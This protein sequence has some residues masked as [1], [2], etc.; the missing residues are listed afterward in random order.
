MD[1]SSSQNRTDEDNCAQLNQTLSINDPY[2]LFDLTRHPDGTVTRKP[3]RHPL[4]STAPD[5]SHPTPV[6]SK[7]VTINETN[8]TRVRIFLP[9]HALEEDSSSSN[10]PLPLIVYYCG[11]GFVILSA[12]TTYCHDICFNMSLQLSAVVV[13]LSYRLAPEHRLPAAYDDAVEA[14]N[15]V[16]NTNDEWLREH[17]DF[18]KVFIMGSSSGGNIAYHVGLRVAAAGVDRFKPLKINGLILHYPY[19]GGAKR[20]ESELRLI[21]NHLMPPWLSDPAWELSLPIG[22]DQDHEY[23]NPMVGDG[24]KLLE[25]IKLLGWKV[26]LSTCDGDWAF[27]RQIQVANMMEEKGIKVE[28]RIVIGDYHGDEATELP[29]QQKLII[30]LKD[31]VF[32]SIAQLSS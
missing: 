25:K 7:D 17:A 3:S 1:F 18:T 19:F 21:N 24:P 29:K 12:A 22:A 10:A 26:L 27:D 32:S 6:L 4:R 11:G 5:L 30:A 31:F 13:S 16:S 15:W 8:H 9:R 14:L 2:D 28:R 20:C 23:C